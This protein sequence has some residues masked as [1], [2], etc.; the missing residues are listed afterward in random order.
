MI[1]NTTIN[2]VQSFAYA[3]LSDLGNAASFNIFSSPMPSNAN[4]PPTGT[5]LANVVMNSPFGYVSNTT[6]NAYASN[7]VT[8]I[9]NGTAAWARMTAANGVNVFDADIGLPASNAT[10]IFNTTALV[11]STL[12]TLTNFIIN[13]G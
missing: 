2:T 13:I 9:A 11:N 10:I 6:I 4:L 8:I 5:L 12:F 3:L 1:L 7:G